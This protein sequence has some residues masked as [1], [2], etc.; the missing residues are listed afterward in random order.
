MERVLAKMPL[1][2][3][4]HVV[5]VEGEEAANK[6]H[7]G[8]VVSVKLQLRR[9]TFAS[10]PHFASDEARDEKDDGDDDPMNLTW[11]NVK[12]DKDAEV[13]EGQAPL[14]EAPF[15]PFPKRE[16]W[17]LIVYSKLDKAIVHLRPL[18]ALSSE[19]EEEFKVFVPEDSA[20]EREYAVYVWSDSYLGCDID[21]YSVKLR[22]QDGAPEAPVDDVVDAPEPEPEPE[23]EPKWYYL[24]AS[25]FG[26]FVLLLLTLAVLFVF[27]VNFLHSKGWLNSVVKVLNRF[28]GPLWNAVGAPVW[29]AIGAPTWGSLKGFVPSNLFDFSSVPAGQAQDEL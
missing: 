14:V 12:A 27:A 10:P 2:G 21:A 1:L 18:S 6:I 29:R 23:P 13:K 25:S 19:H 3:L 20:P 9:G 8:D 7:R 16:L 22:V 28:L 24:Y 17:H 5:E 26:E 4:R 15:F 11:K